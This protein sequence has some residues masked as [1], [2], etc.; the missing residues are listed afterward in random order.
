[1]RDSRE[2]K[3]WVKA[4]D[5][6]LEIYRATNSF[7][8]EERYSLISQMRRSSSSIPTN[9]AE[10]FGRIGDAELAR[11]LQISLGSAAELEYQILLA[12][13][14]NLFT[15]S[16]HDELAEKVIEVK[17]MLGGLLKKVRSDK[18]RA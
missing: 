15:E 9:I 4:H 3:V 13:D 7:S 10:G 8:K 14:L 18:C 5:L 11:F 12:K 17:R 16:K 2:I 1:M 6:T